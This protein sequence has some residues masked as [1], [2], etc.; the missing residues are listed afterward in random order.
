MQQGLV[1]VLSAIRAPSILQVTRILVVAGTHAHQNPSVADAF[2]VTRDALLRHVPTDQCANNTASSSARSCTSQ[3]S[4]S[5]TRKHDPEAGDSHACSNSNNGSSY[6]S[7][8]PTDGSADAG[9]L[10]GL[11]SE[12]RFFAA[13][14]EVTRTSFVRHDEVDIVGF[15]TALRQYA[16][17]TFCAFAVR[18]KAVSVASRPHCADAGP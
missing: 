15:V 6:R 7:K 1:H 5:R 17:A 8:C 9:A 13:F 11:R 2:V 4:N 3:C 18:E 10:G 16:I 14:D 12:F